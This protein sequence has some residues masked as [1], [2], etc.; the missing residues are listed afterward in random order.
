MAPARGRGRKHLRH[1]AAALDH[2]LGPGRGAGILLPPPAERQSLG[3]RLSPCGGR[4]HGSA[5]CLHRLSPAPAGGG[6]AIRGAAYGRHAARERRGA[7]L[8]ARRHHRGDARLRGRVRHQSRRRGV[9]RPLALSALPADPRRLRHPLASLPRQSRHELRGA[10]RC[11]LARDVEARVRT[12]P[13]RLP[14]C[15]PHLH[16]SR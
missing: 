8:S 7:C 9:R 15:R 5:A 1:Q 10:R 3:C 13:L 12:A 16:H 11:H 14:A 2:A 4:S 6:R